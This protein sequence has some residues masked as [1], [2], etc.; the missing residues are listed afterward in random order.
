MQAAARYPVR[1]T[2]FTLA[3]SALTVAFG[4]APA[5]CD[6]ESHARKV[7]DF[8]LKAL[9]GTQVSLHER[10][11]RGPVLISFWATWCKPC[12][13]E[14][15]HLDEIAKQYREKGLSVFAI[16][17]DQPR[18]HNRVRSYMQSHK[19]TFDVLLDP[20]QDAY[21]K[22]NGQSV[23]YVLVLDTSGEA[24]YVKL[25]YRPGDEKILE[26]SIAALFDGADG[27][28]GSAGDGAPPDSAAKNA[29]APPSGT[30][31]TDAPESEAPEMGQR[32][33]GDGR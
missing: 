32:R 22:L 18:S 12:L 27:E 15:P 6:E 2:L 16:S 28:H 20:N 5:R 30:T 10:L 23:P 24:A 31:E 1:R 11:D 7:A 25:G 13:Q 26:E 19:Y 8:R 3:L 14:M 4:P 17:I 33:D 21:R 29:E 9:D